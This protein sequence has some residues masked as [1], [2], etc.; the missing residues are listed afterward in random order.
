M[1]RV[2]TMG[3]SATGIP[4]FGLRLVSAMLSVLVL[5]CNLMRDVTGCFMGMVHTS[6]DG[7]TVRILRK[8]ST[9]AIPAI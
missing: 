1:N 2:L 5:A 6:A 4:A 3:V 7:D 8:I 9:N